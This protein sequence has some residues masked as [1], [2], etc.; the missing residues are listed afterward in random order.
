[1]RRTWGEWAGECVR[2]RQCLTRAESGEEQAKR[3]GLPET[4]RADSLLA[5]YFRARWSELMKEKP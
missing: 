3:L 5:E 2:I 1:M 4:A